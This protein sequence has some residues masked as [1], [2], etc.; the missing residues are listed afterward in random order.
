MRLALDS[1]PQPAA[2][3]EAPGAPVL[4][5]V[6][7]LSSA[8]P[9]EA[10]QRIEA[11]L[12][13]RHGDR[14]VS[15]A[16]TSWEAGEAVV[17]PAEAKAAP[18]LR[19]PPLPT[20]GVEAHQSGLKAVLEY[21]L[22]QKA[23][24]IALVA[25]EPH[26]DAAGWLD[27]FLAPVLERGLDF[28]SPVYLR[29]KAEG[30]LNTGIVYPL[31]RAL[32]GRRLRQPLGG[33]AAFS[34]GLAQRLVDDG[35][36]RTEPSRAGSDGWLVAKVLTSPARACQAW[37]GHWPRPDAQPEDVSQTLARVLGMVFH[38]MERHADAWQ[39]VSGSTPVETFGA[40]GMLEGGAAPPVERFVSAFQLGERELAPIWGLVLPPATRVALHRAAALPATAF[41]LDDA[42]W[43]KVVY[44][45]AVAH[46]A[47]V[48]E[49]HQ[50]LHSLTPLYLG[51]V[52]SF[53]SE[54]LALDAAAIEAR[55][56]KLCDVFEQQ[57]RY[58]ISRWRW[59]DSFNP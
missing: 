11:A 8:A 7:G 36:W 28:V 54:T 21:G 30:A 48:I 51:W 39:R 9:G 37:L 24:A 29:H 10:A 57:K 40:A 47:R 50:L 6:D 49:P 25:A 23:G 46:Y 17:R 2:P 26:D 22:A 33:E 53:A 43:V 58:L 52:A 34:A 4:V 27:T 38:E 32:Y 19:A 44:D 1:P 13:A 41:R 55:V 31:T 3:V 18:A 56:E 15:V 16:V 5:V 35:D 42:T 20:G 14:P 59:P 45:F 12:R